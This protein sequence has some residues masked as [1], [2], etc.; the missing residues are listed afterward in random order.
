MPDLCYIVVCNDAVP[1]NGK[2]VYLISEPVQQSD[3]HWLGG[4]SIHIANAILYVD[5]DSARKVSNKIAKY[6][7]AYNV[8]VIS[9]EAKEMFIA[10]LTG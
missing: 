10:K 7:P 6:Y 1:G 5:H 8:K 3:T 2:L 4:F 9:K